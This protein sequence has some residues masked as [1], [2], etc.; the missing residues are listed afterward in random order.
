MNHARS[1][2]LT[3]EVIST[4]GFSRGDTPSHGSPSAASRGSAARF[5][6]SNRRY[7]VHPFVTGEEC[8]PSLN[9]KRPV[10]GGGWL[11]GQE[12]RQ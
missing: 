11:S 7:F 4:F 2:R 3:A 12:E 10:F 6:L 8:L 9:D 1:D 5:R